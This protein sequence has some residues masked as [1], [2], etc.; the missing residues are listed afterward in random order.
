MRKTVSSVF[1]NVSS[2]SVLD[3]SLSIH[4]LMLLNNDNENESALTLIGNL[5][6]TMK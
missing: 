2:F 3:W 6:V 5:L 1:L 4:T